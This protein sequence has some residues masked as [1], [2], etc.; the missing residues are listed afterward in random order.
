MADPLESQYNRINEKKVLLNYS[1][2]SQLIT[3]LNEL[4]ATL[5]WN[6]TI[7]ADEK[8]RTLQDIQRLIEL[9]ARLLPEPA[10]ADD[11]GVFEE[12]ISEQLTLELLVGKQLKLMNHLMINQMAVLFDG[13]PNAV[14]A[15]AKR[16][17][18]AA[19]ERTIIELMQLSPSKES[20][21]T[22]ARPAE[23]QANGG[24]NEEP[25][26]ESSANGEPNTSGEMHQNGQREN[27]GLH[28]NVGQ[29]ESR[30]PREN[31]RLN[32]NVGPNENGDRSGN[33]GL[34]ENGSRSENDHSNE[35]NHPNENGDLNESEPSGENGEPPS[36]KRRSR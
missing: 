22:G 17:L 32:E 35:N 16:S 8:Q 2:R 23:D 12:T 28:Q 30:G 19:N 13:K 3:R 18:A 34:I 31:S 33:G 15:E 24:T 26:E 25:S 29:N 6:E 27:G 4:S 9:L 5:R 11:S 7:P 36:K 21:F 10:S 14:T 20:G 1:T